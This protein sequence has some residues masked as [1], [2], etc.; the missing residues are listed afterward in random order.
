MNARDLF[1]YENATLM[2]L[3]QY[4]QTDIIPATLF[5]YF[6]YDEH[7]LLTKIVL[8]MT[9]LRENYASRSSIIPQ[10]HQERIRSPER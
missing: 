5:M 9:Q 2:R 4:L 1:E 8:R 3:L 7:S 10:K 6:K